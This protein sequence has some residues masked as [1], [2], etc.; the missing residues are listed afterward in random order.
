MTEMREL[1][2]K[3][4]DAPDQAVLA[5]AGAGNQSIAWLLGVAGA[6]RTLLEVVVPYGPLSM[7][8]LVGYEPDQ[9]VSEKTAQDMARAG[10]RRALRL[11]EGAPP[12]L[13]LGCTATIATDRPKR[14]EHRCHIATWDQVRLATYT[15]VL[16]KG[17]RDRAGEDGVVS[18]LLV[19]ALAQACGIDAEPN[20]GLTSADRLTFR[21]QHHEDPLARLLAGDASSVT[22]QSDGTMAVDEPVHAAI[23]PGSFSPFHQGHANLAR[24]AGD[25]LGGDVFFEISVLNVDKPPLSEPEVRQR[26]DQFLGKG[27]VVLTRAETFRKKADL[28]PGCTFVIGWDTAIRL[29]APRYYGGDNTDMLT[30]LAEMWTAGCR[31]LVAG[32]RDEGGTFRTLEDVAVPGG[33]SPLFKSIPESRYREDISSTALREMG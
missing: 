10:Y 22:V 16:D 15:L 26:L 18:R 8:E 5:V 6:S 3:I 12:V 7:R 4:H 30:A 13:G 17:H 19:Q 27:N 31:F 29:V 11:R 14:G 20:L 32:R 1:I 25:M 21:R 2:Q 23:L 9:F 24:I 33:F 28:F